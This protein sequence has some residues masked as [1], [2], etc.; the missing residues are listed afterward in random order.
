MLRRNLALGFAALA[1]VLGVFA[2]QANA[3]Q[4]YRGMFNLPYTTYWG[5]TVLQ[6]GEYT[7]WIEKNQPGSDLLR[8]SGNG[9]V[10]T[11]FIGPVERHDV[12]PHGSIHLANVNGIYALKE[13]DAGVIGRTFSFSVPKKINGKAT[14]ASSGSAVDIAVQ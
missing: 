3:E 1:G 10:A 4:A 6:P 13:F 12:T 14:S 7:V 2:T 9:T 5:G 8:V 11:A